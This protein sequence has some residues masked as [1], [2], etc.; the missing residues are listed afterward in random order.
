MLAC[1]KSQM[2]ILAYVIQ[3]CP[4]YNMTYIIYG[5]YNMTYITYTVLY[6]ILPYIIYVILYDYYICSFPNLCILSLEFAGCAFRT[7]LMS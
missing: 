3:G 1:P 2:E 6:T 5:I 4:S 7:S